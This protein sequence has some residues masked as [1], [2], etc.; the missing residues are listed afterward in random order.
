MSIHGLE[1]LAWDH[2][3]LPSR[4][5]KSLKQLPNGCW[6]ADSRNKGRGLQN[7]VVTRVTER[8]AYDALAITPTCGDMRCANPAHLCVTW[9]TPVTEGA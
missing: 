9:R 2:A 6:V 5:W 4:F 7:T 3:R 1:P 8:S